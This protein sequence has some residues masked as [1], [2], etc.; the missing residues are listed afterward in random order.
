MVLSSERFI[1]LF[2]VYVCKSS[3]AAGVCMYTTFV[4][5]EYR[6]QER[7]MDFSG[8]EVDGDKLPHRY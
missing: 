6:G 8:T 2:Q 7:E 3:P 5:G 1:C 4:P